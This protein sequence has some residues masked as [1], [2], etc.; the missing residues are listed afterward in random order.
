MMFGM[1]VVGR[2]MCIFQARVRFSNRE[3]G[4]TRKYMEV[5]RCRILG[6]ICLWQCYDHSWIL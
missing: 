4:R 5:G 6:E 1:V 2:V 3:G